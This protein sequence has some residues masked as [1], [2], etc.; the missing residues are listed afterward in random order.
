MY[1]LI[2]FLCKINKLMLALDIHF[3]CVN[4]VFDKFHECVVV[5]HG[6]HEYLSKNCNLYVIVSTA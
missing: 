1:I 4:F 6:L 2:I 3:V 5:I